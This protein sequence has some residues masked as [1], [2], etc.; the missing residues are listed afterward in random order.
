MSATNSNRHGVISAATYPSRRLLLQGGATVLL[1]VSAAGCDLLSTSPSNRPTSTGSGSNGRQSPELVTQVR[2]GKLPKLADRLPATPLMVKPVDRV[3]SYG[4]TWRTALEGAADTSWL[5]RSIG[6]EQLLR[7]SQDGTK[8][9]PNVAE[10]VRTEQDGRSYVF[11][12]RRG[13]RWSDGEPFGVDDVIFAFEDVLGNSELSPVFPSDL[14]VGGK[15]PTVTRLDDHTLRVSFAEPFGLFLQRL[16]TP[17]AT[18]LTASPKHY[19]ERFHMKYNTDVATLAKEGKFSTWVELFGARSDQ[20][21]NPDLPTVHGWRLTSALGKGSRVSAER[22]PFYFKT[23]TKGNQLP[24]IDRVTYRVVNN[25][26][27]TL[28]LA[29]NGELDMHTRSIN[30]LIN[31]PVLARNRGKGD[32]HFVDITTDIMNQVVIMLNL[33][34]EDPMLRAVFQNKNFRIGLSYAIN[35]AEISDAVFQRQ[36]E[37]WQVAP[38]KESTFYH[39]RLATQYTEYDLDKARRYL[40][41]AGYDTTNS[42]GI[43][44]RPDGKPISF[45]VEIATG[46]PYPF[47]TDVMTLVKG[48]WRRV[49]VDLRIKSEDR[50]LFEERTAANK[51]DAAVW[52]GGGGLDDAILHPYCYFPSEAGSWFA[53]PWATWFLSGGSDGE[54]PPA[55][56]R[57]QMDLYRRANASVDAGQ[58][59]DL[60]RQVLDVAA[61]QFWVI[62]TVKASQSYG[63]VKNNV[64]N[65]PKSIPEAF[66]FDTPALTNPSQYFIG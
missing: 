53:V 46:T 52:P 24:Y 39:E 19:L 33:A 38:A 1:A 2:S 26:E 28:L 13:M 22:N 42:D 10:K 15:P 64:H 62:G 30:T 11:T 27:T 17:S 48:Y 59:R 12:L 45:A 37:P 31:K 32:Y 40:D 41:D 51:H 63:I 14:T 23:D 50:S 18:V 49:G 4:G 55:P 34:H 44:L 5:D 8:P 61:E 25:T 65:V 57:K 7:W 16:C 20:W 58:R 60:F 47:M 3:G 36:G 54:Q 66:Y 43:R 29:M 6:Y 9:L 35:R 56:A 21:V